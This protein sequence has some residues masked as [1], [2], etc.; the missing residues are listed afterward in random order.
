MQADCL[1][2]EVM[3]LL[4]KELNHSDDVTVNRRFLFALSSLVRQYPPALAQFLQLNGLQTLTK[5]LTRAESGVLSL[6]SLTL[7]TDL[8]VEQRSG[9]DETSSRITSSTGIRLLEMLRTQGWCQLT[10]KLLHRENDAD[11]NEKVI[12]AMDAMIQGCGGEFIA[13]DVTEQV[14]EAM[15]KWKAALEQNDD[16]YYET[17]IDMTTQFLNKLKHCEKTGLCA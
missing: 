16:G 17:L 15:E 7:V 10:P 12:Q 8:L 9:A 11:R 6:K 14:E 5:Y 4:L 1:E 3:Q 13:A 2:Y